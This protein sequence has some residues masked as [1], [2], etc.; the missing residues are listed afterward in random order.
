MKKLNLSIIS[1]LITFN[2]TAEYYYQ[3]PMVVLDRD[4]NVIVSND[5]NGGSGTPFDPTTSV[6]DN[7]PSDINTWA[8]FLQNNVQ[9]YNGNG[10]GHYDPTHPPAPIFV[11]GVSSL[12]SSSIGTSS[13]SYSEGGEEEGGCEEEEFCPS[14]AMTISEI[15]NYMYTT[16]FVYKQYGNSDPMPT[17]TGLNQVIHEF[18]IQNSSISAITGVENITHITDG[19]L[20]FQNNNLVDYSGLSN[21]QETGAVTIM[22]SPVVDISFLSNLVKGNMDIWGTPI[23]NIQNLNSNLDC[24]RFTM[25]GSSINSIDY[26]NLETIFQNGCTDIMLH[27]NNLTN[28]NSLSGITELEN[29]RLNGNQITDLSGLSDVVRIN[30][31]LT[32]H[33]N[34]NLSDLTPLSNLTYIGG[35]LS[36]EHTNITNLNGLQNLSTAGYISLYEQ[37]TIQSLEGLNNLTHA[38]NIHIVRPANLT[39][40]DALQ[41]LTSVEK[42]LT[43]ENV[44]VPNFQGLSGLETVGWRLAISSPTATSLDGLENLR[45]VGLEG[46]QV[47]FDSLRDISALNN[48]ESMDGRLYINYA[49][50]MSGGKLRSDHF[51]CQDIA[52]KVYFGYNVTPSASTVNTVRNRIC[53]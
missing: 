22:Y 51:I 21:L 19:I 15:E 16:G 13:L 42:R 37:D 11:T 12:S 40:I 24:E 26:P 45:H 27:Y 38:D 53:E 7:D 35:E 2:L 44:N 4:Q 1:I 39:N 49:Y 32:L 52:N 28:V 23:T 20:F 25:T 3:I 29:L 31:S 47:Y 48:L 8:S 41:N 36:L 17:I 6:N 9:P 33:E 43:L 10:A 34:P 5:T 30:N 18:E 50:N 46:I 14:P